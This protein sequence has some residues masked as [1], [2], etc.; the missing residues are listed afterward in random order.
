MARKCSPQKKNEQGGFY[1]FFLNFDF[2]INKNP[3]ESIKVDS[4][5]Y[6]ISAM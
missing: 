5:I 6:I 2:T 3:M 1:S 4:I